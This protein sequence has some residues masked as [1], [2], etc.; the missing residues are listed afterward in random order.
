MMAGHLGKTRR[1]R[2]HVRQ[3]TD[4]MRLNSSIYRS[5]IL[6][7]LIAF[8]AG[9]VSPRPTVNVVANTLQT[10]RVGQTTFKNFKSD[11]GLVIT[12]FPKQEYLKPSSQLDSKTQVVDTVPKDSAWKIYETRRT[13]TLVNGN[14]SQSAQFVVGDHQKPISILTFDDKG[15][16]TNISPVP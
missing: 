7:A 14:L 2:A 12:V 15:N 11:S 8:M 13:S 9:C 16:L 3:V 5:F 4:A 6:M 1:E 10:Y